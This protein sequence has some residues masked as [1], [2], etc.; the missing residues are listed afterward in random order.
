MQQTQQAHFAGLWY[1][2]SFYEIVDHSMRNVVS[3]PSQV[4]ERTPNVCLSCMV[5][6]ILPRLRFHDDRLGKASARRAP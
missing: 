4:I 2:L 6:F 3:N 1:P 5:V